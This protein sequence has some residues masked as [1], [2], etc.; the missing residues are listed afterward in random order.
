MGVCFVECGPRLTAVNG[1]RLDYFSCNEWTCHLDHSFLQ[2]ELSHLT[3]FPSLDA[4]LRLTKPDSTLLHDPN[5]MSGDPQVPML[6]GHEGRY[7]RTQEYSSGHRGDVGWKI[8]QPPLPFLSREQVG[9]RRAVRAEKVRINATDHGFAE[10]DFVCPGFFSL[11][12]LDG[13]TPPYDYDLWTYEMRRKAQPIFPFLFLGPS[14]CCRDLTFLQAEE[15]TLLLAVRNRHSATA[16]L[17]SGEKAAA[18]LGTLAD[19]MDVLDSQEL[20][21]TFPRAIRRIN[22]HLAG[23]DVD[24]TTVSNMTQG[25]DG[26]QRRKVLIFCESGN[27]RS[28]VLVIAYLMVMVN[29]SAI[30]A[31]TA[32]LERRFCVSIDEP[33]RRI[34]DSFESILSA[35]RDVKCAVHTHTQTG[36]ATLAPLPISAEL[37]SKKRSFADRQDDDDNVD[38][39]D[40]DVD[41][42]A[43]DDLHWER[44]PFAPFRDAEA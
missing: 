26:A 10:D 36:A 44:R 25:T 32:V 13:L 38:M 9:N 31:T 15:F 7:I 35:K 33:M 24:P 39:A 1:Y 20:I 3:F 8:N 34:L 27:E 18:E 14:S 42:D 37:L 2:D 23:I 12:H 40:G 5:I 22:D 41:I 19:T 11:V 28:A 16:R 21:H 43:E 4:C 29:L 6:Q 30:Q 17:V